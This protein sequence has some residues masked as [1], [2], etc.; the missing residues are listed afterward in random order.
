MFVPPRTGIFKVANP[1]GQQRTRLD[2]VFIPEGRLRLVAHDTWNLIA[3]GDYVDAY[4]FLVFRQAGE[5]EVDIA[6]RHPRSVANR[7]LSVSVS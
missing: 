2:A 4:Y 7:T 1:L 3:A 6:V 5:H